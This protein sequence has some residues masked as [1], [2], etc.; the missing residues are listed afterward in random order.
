MLA[1]KDLI[2]LLNKNRD[3]VT[4]IFELCNDNSTTLNTIKIINSTNIDFI[5]I[6]N[7]AVGKL[8][9]SN[10]SINNII[11]I[12]N[13]NNSIIGYIINKNTSKKQICELI[14]KF[15]N[16][17]IALIH[18][19]TQLEI[20][21]IAYIH[22]LYNIIKYNIFIK[23]PENSYLNFFKED[24]RVLIKDFFN[25]SIRNSDYP[26][27]EVF[28]TLFSTLRKKYVGFGD[29]QIV[30]DN[31]SENGG[32][33]NSVA[34]HLTYLNT[35]NQIMINHFISDDIQ[36]TQNVSIKYFQALF[37]LINFTNNYNLTPKTLGITNFEANYI[38]KLY[39]G[40]GL[41]KRYS[42]EHHIELMIYL[43]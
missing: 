2:P 31:Y 34:L 33:A 7:P 24:T 16:F 11:N 25:K 19:D 37:K 5:V 8:V 13:P 39:H 40:L 36:G 15:S 4:P 22:S 38:S 9:N 21:T 27:T 42:I 6:I 20:E 30:G 32:P 1:I 10:K 17:R 18:N 43:I 41:P 14:N 28:S 3:K 35:N 23:E 12:L 29:Y 26:Q